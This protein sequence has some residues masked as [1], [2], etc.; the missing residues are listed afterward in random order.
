MIPFMHLALICLHCL[1]RLSQIIALPS[2]YLI[3]F[4]AVSQ[5]PHYVAS[6]RGRSWLDLRDRLLLLMRLKGPPGT[7]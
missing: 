4:G 6:L 1:L 5:R 3:R 2:F 7:M